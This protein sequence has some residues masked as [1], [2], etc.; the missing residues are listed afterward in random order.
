M[1]RFGLPDDY[2]ERAAPAYA[3]DQDGIGFQPHVY[4]LAGALA[5]MLGVKKIFDVGC[6][7]G[8]KLAA[9]RE[10][11]FE[12]IGLDY[13]ANLSAA[14]QLLYG[15]W[16]EVNFERFDASQYER[17]ADAAVIICADVIEHLI[18][19][20]CLVAALR[21]WLAVSPVA[22]LSTPER[23]L[24]WGAAHRG[25]PPNTAHIREWTRVELVEYLTRSG[26]RVVFSGFT[27][28][29]LAHPETGAHQG[30]QTTLVLLQGGVL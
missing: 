21:G 16:H 4:D 13:G 22:L 5:S 29:H 10:R 3:H 23:V 30:C 20:T 8:H 25:P 19:P 26:L 1:N 15:S 28:T 7:M 6:G 17:L 27:Q 18:D 9:L 11:G 24:C 12:V 14:R 2:V